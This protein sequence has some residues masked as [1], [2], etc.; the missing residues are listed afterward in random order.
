M[1]FEGNDGRTF[2]QIMG[3]LAWLPGCVLMKKVELFVLRRLENRGDQHS[4]SEASGQAD[5]LSRKPNMA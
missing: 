4:E 3:E 1:T 2:L 5:S